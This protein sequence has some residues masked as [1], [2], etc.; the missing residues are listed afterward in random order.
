MSVFI[1]LIRVN[2]YKI[3][4]YCLNFII[5]YKYLYRNTFL[6][7]LN[8]HIKI[9]YGYSSLKNFLILICNY[10]NGKIIFMLFFKNNNKIR[11]NKLNKF[12]NNRKNKK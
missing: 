8:T 2:K 6:I 3:N 4:F 5:L 11:L 7:N 1:L 10:S 9:N 12:Y